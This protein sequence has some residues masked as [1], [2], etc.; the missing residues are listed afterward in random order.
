MEVSS[1]KG[2]E[3]EIKKFV[4]ARWVCPQ[5]ALWRIYKYQ[6]NKI[7]P[8]VVS[9]QIHLKYQQKIFLPEGRT[10]REVLRREKASLQSLLNINV[11]TVNGRVN[12]VLARTNNYYLRLLLN[13]VRDPTF[14]EDLLKVGS[15][16]FSMYREV[17]QHLDLLESDTSMRD[18][19]LE[20]TQVHMPSSLRRLFCTL[21]TLGPN[22]MKKYKFPAI[23]EDVGTSGTNDLVMEE[24]SIH[25]PPEDLSAIGRINNDQRHA[26]DRAVKSFNRCE[27]SIFIID[28]PGGSGKTFLYRTILAFLRT[29]GHIAIATATSGIA[30]TMMPSGRIAHSRFK[31]PVPADSTSTCDIP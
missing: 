6:M 16:T 1:E 29:E 8:P 2:D 15:V 4:D 21:S 11:T 26:F 19:L 30:A 31:I 7:C 24:K 23:T 9:L 5:E 10:V 13:N 22:L 20:A 18:T 28:G 3:D 27:S 17:S 14:F 12:V 25:I